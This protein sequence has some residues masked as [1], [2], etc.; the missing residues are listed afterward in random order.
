LIKALLRTKQYPKLVLKVWLL[1]PPRAA[2][3]LPRCARLQSAP[4]LT[5]QPAPM[6]L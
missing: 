1:H 3:I 4:P 5:Q 6:K 2:A